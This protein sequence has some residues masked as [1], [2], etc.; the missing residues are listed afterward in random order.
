MI[1]IIATVCL[2]AFGL[3][4][5]WFSPL[6]QQ[7]INRIPEKPLHWLERLSIFD[8]Y[9]F[10]CRV[11]QFSDE[12]QPIRRD[13]FFRVEIIGRIPTQQDNV[14]TNVQIEILDIT[15]GRSGVHQILS[16]DEDYRRDGSVE[17]YYLKHNGL[18]PNKNSILSRW[19]TVVQFPCHIL[20]FAYRGRRKLLFRST[21]L[22]AASGKQIV[23]AQQTVEFVYCS[24]GYR[25]VHGRRLDVLGSCIELSAFVLEAES[26]SDGLEAM[27]SN[28]IQQKGEMYISTDEASEIIAKAKNR[29]IGETPQ[30]AA[31][32]ILAYGKNT[33]RFYAAELALQT[34]S[35]VGTVSRQ[36]LDKLFRISSMLEI[37]RDRFLNLA[38]KILLSSHCRIEDPSQL[39]GI[40][41]GMGD[42]SF[43]KQL[44]EEYR[45]WNARVTH[46][47]S[48]IRAQA[49]QILSLIAEIRSQ[50]LQST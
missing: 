41:S 31:D 11:R 13:Q 39:L 30:S 37:Q 18:V 16:G 46:P 32:I 17:F 43:R 49:D 10:T 42:E 9:R 26:C 25:E 3:F 36:N 47:D 38:Q 15:D 7:L 50:W 12:S 45:K 29:R 5:L 22:D 14:D 40:A 27:W 1:W 33:D 20:R 48:Q 35:F 6:R 23:A 24:D 19:V 28:W 34:V 21:V 2:S 8:R 4:A 44:N